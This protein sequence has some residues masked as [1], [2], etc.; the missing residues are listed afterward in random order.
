MGRGF[1]YQFGP[2]QAQGS[3]LQDDKANAEK[4]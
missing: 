2:T 4:F 1:L 3:L